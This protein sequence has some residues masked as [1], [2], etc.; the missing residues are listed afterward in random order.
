MDCDSRNLYNGLAFH[1]LADLEK[2]A[3]LYR[4]E[5]ARMSLLTDLFFLLPAL[6]FISA[7]NAILLYLYERNEW[8]AVKVYWIGIGVLCLVH[9]GLFP[10]F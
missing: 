4:L 9:L 2:S 1:L 7:T 10:V 5:W 3:M 6:S 8:E